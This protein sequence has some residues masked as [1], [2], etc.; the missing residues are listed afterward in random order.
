MTIEARFMC[1]RHESLG[2]Q[3]AAVS[4][5]YGVEEAVVGL[6]IPPLRRML[7]DRPRG[8]LGSHVRRHCW[9]LCEAAESLG[10]AK[11][12]RLGAQAGPSWRGQ[13]DGRDDVRMTSASPPP[14][15]H[16][17]GKE[18]GHL[19][20]GRG[21]ARV[22]RGTRRNPTSWSAFSGVRTWAS[23]SATARMTPEMT[24]RATR[25]TLRR[26]DAI[27]LDDS[28]RMYLRQIGAN[29]PPTQGTG[30][31]IRAVDRAG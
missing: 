4:L 17:P 26:F 3:K 28:T 5:D 23:R 22:G 12:R 14:M 6:R 15:A 29:G 25:R 7:L 16:H 1:A 11:P 27:S 10:Q 9:V 8:P 13:N 31:R 20:P 24:S 21:R 30:D 2:S 18:Q 19:T